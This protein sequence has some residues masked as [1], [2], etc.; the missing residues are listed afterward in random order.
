MVLHRQALVPGGS[1]PF[2]H[3]T[4]SWVELVRSA[5]D[6]C[7]GNGTVHGGPSALQDTVR[8][9]VQTN[10][11]DVLG[12]W[13]E[14]VR[15]SRRGAQATKAS[16]CKFVLSVRVREP[17]EHYLSAYTWAVS[18]DMKPSR[19]SGSSRPTTDAQGHVRPQLMPFMAW[20]REAANLQS[21]SL[22]YGHGDAYVTVEIPQNGARQIVG[23]PPPPMTDED[24]SRLLRSI[25]EDFD[26]V[27]PL[28]GAEVETRL[29][30]GRAGGE[31]ESRGPYGVPAE[32]SA[33][34]GSSWPLF[35]AG[36]RAIAAKLHL[37]PRALA[38]LEQSHMPH[39]SPRLPFYGGGLTGSARKHAW[40]Q[41][42]PNMSACKELVQRVAPFDHQLFD[43][44]RALWWQRRYHSHLRSHPP[45]HPQR[46]NVRDEGRGEANGEGRGKRWGS[47]ATLQASSMHA[48]APRSHSR[49]CAPWDL[50]TAPELGEACRL[51]RS[52]GL[53]APLVRALRSFSGVCEPGV[54]AVA[55]QYFPTKPRYDRA[56]DMV[57]VQHHHYSGGGSPYTSPPTTLSAATAT[58][59]ADAAPT[60]A[61]GASRESRVSSEARASSITAASDAAA[62][63]D[64]SR[65]LEITAASNAALFDAAPANGTRHAPL[66]STALASSSSSSR[67]SP[68]AI[69]TSRRPS[70]PELSA[71]QSASIAS[72]PPLGTEWRA[73]LGAVAPKDAECTHEIRITFGFSPPSSK[74]STIKLPLVSASPC[75]I[76]L[77]DERTSFKNGENWTVRRLREWP[78]PTDLH[79]ST[80]VAKVHLHK[81][82]HG[83]GRA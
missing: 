51:L 63:A 60:A 50:L 81:H 67:A 22:L 76:V 64:L 21:R 56:A 53:P 2:E 33:A 11:D 8:L 34:S 38:S 41:A 15:T 26:V 57:L 27:T 39:V 58:I 5:R 70:H 17:L 45:T 52:S 37:P 48:S 79:R 25:E 23:K 24:F 75:N 6:A 42:C 54:M 20:A 80:H 68:Q 35:A 29:G 55:G 72:C 4:K 65:S 18:A 71:L 30:G 82:G 40:Q 16:C 83:R 32:G 69:S 78:W 13:L 49:R 47:K 74:A 62:L 46:G 44:T 61:G 59:V 28:G 10:S 12:T 19:G 3:T 43:R 14:E 77:S 66:T 1:I 73:L 31:A 7:N 9:S 36:A